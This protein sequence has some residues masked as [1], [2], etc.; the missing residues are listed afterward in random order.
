LSQKNNTLTY[1]Q[2]NCCP[3]QAPAASAAK[4]WFEELVKKKK[5]E[6]IQT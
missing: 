2:S 4:Q 3:T 6:K 5:L 1:W